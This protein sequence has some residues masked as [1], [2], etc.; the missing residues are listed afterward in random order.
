MVDVDDGEIEADHQYEVEER[1]TSGSISRGFSFCWC[2]VAGADWEVI[3]AR[4][5]IGTSD[6]TTTIT[7]S[8]DSFLSTLWEGEPTM[9]KYYF[10]SSNFK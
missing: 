2:W 9:I 6:I 5:T 4:N 8:W 1:E 3:G 10:N 7:S